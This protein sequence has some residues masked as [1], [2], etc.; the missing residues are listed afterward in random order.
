MIEQS[1]QPKW[2]SGSEQHFGWI[3]GG[4]GGESDRRVCLYRMSK[5]TPDINPKLKS[6][7]KPR[8]ERVVWAKRPQ[9]DSSEIAQ[10]R[11]VGS[12]GSQNLIGSASVI[13]G[14]TRLARGAH[15]PADSVQ[16]ITVATS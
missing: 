7:P 9:N 8:T 10:N 4:A 1:G 3:H 6:I 14:P 2:I 15:Q 16:T 13:T 11:C 5:M 12:L